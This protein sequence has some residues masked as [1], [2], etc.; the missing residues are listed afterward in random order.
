MINIITMAGRMT[1]KLTRNNNS[2]TIIH[3]NLNKS[4]RIILGVEKGKLKTK[5]GP[6]FGAIGPNLGPKFPG[7][8]VL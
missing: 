6:I 5:F 1:R 4:R 7:N 8:C 3:I 2:A